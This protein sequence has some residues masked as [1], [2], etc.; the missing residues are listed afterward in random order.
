MDFQAIS[1]VLTTPVLWV[2]LQKALPGLA[3]GAVTWLALYYGRS[4]AIRA[5]ESGKR[6]GLR[7]WL[8]KA[9]WGTRAWFPLVLA[10]GLAVSMMPLP[11]LAAKLAAH[12]TALL[13]LLQLGFWVNLLLEEGAARHLSSH[14]GDGVRATT[15]STLL[16]VAHIL[17]WALVLL[18]ALDNVGVDVTAMVAGLGIGGVALAFASQN[19]LQNLFASVGMIFDSPFVLGDFIISK[20]TMGTVKQ[21]GMKNTRI[22][23]LSG[24]E[25]IVPNNDLLT[26]RIQNFGRMTERR[27]VFTLMVE[28]GT[29]AD[30]LEI[31]PGIIRQAIESKRNTRFDRSH[32]QGFQPGGLTF[33]TVYYMTLSD[34]NLMMDT[35]QAINLDLYRAFEEHQV[36]FAI[37]LQKTIYAPASAATRGLASDELPPSFPAAPRSNEG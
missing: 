12:A 36:N 4:Y 25:V 5:L 18:A 32:F 27:V 20:E 19:I 23:A 14:P 34:Y 9:L 3:V 15:V 33:E 2:A 28:Y 13:F 6:S 21:I 11:P 8:L 26:T 37:P 7:G 29:P 10:V 35:Q 17:V 22:Q 30:T 1:Q 31:L 24:E 16:M